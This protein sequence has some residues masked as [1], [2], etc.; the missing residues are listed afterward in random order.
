M[1]AGLL[2]ITYCLRN[3]LFHGTKWHL[4]LSDQYENL[5]YGTLVLVETLGSFTTELG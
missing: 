5:A 2:L 1:L 4:G 3:N